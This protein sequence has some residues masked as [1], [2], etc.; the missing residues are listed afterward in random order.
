MPPWSAL[1]N[2]P[3]GRAILLQCLSPVRRDKA[4]VQP[5]MGR[6]FASPRPDHQTASA[7]T[8]PPRIP[9]MSHLVTRRTAITGSLLAAPFVLVCPILTAV[10]AGLGDRLRA[11]ETRRGG[12]L[13]AAVIDTANGA[14]ATHRADERF[15]MCSTVKFLSAA[16]ALT[17]VDRGEEELTRRIVVQS[18]DVVSHSPAT[19]RR[20]GQ[21]MT[22]G[23]LCEAA[24]TLSDSTAGNLLLGGAGGPAGLTHFA[25]SLGDRVTRVDRP[26]PAMAATSLDDPRDTTSPRVMAENV[27][28]LLLGDT[29]RP[30]SRA[31]LTAWLVANRTG[32][33]RIRA[34]LP[35]GWRVGDKTGSGSGGECNDIAI[36]WPPGRAPLVLSLYYVKPG[37]S[38]AVRNAVIAEAARL[39]VAGL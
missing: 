27:R 12:R 14:S 33:E 11:L 8:A 13:G 35:P 15:A 6:G 23:E 5:Q 9:P 22:V 10:G 25:R 21:G 17:R 37:A 16:E 38:S 1:P 36:V 7:G 20:A 26:A 4:F 32:D 34:G 31:L 29:L 30:A 39:V 24:I 28:T 2:R 19:A 3:N 18:G